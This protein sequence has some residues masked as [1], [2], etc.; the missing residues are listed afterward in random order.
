MAGICSVGGYWRRHV[1]FAPT[2]SLQPV[3]KVGCPCLFV[4][5]KVLKLGNIFNLEEKP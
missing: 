3:E 2:Y 5:T 4:N 1:F